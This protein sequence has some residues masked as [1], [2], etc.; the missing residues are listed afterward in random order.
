MGDRIDLIIPPSKIANISMG[1]IGLVSLSMP[2]VG[3]QTNLDHFGGFSWQRLNWY[4][5]A[6]L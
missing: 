2:K 4:S 5:S 1:L 6:G 3:C